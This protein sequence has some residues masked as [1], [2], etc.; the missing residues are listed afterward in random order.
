MNDWYKKGELPPVGE[1][2]ELVSV[3]TTYF[4]RE[5]SITYRG[6][7]VGCY[8]ETKTGHEYTFASAVTKFRPIKSERDKL[9]EKACEVMKY[10]ESEPLTIK[11]KAEALLDAGMLRM[12]END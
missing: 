2:V 8:K 9:I 5:V 4:N 12:P 10:S 3:G 7:G 6:D 11:G 1:V